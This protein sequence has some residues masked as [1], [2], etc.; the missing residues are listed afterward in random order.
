MEEVPQEADPRSPLQKRLSRLLGMEV[1]FATDTVGEDAKAKAAALKPGQI[2]LLENLR[3]D[4]GR[5]QERPQV[6]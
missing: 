3:F 1:I 6:C 4:K 5:D 2:M